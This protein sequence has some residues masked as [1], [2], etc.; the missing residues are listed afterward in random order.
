MDLSHTKGSSKN[1]GIEP[2]L[3]FLHYIPVIKEVRKGGQIEKFDIESITQ[4]A[5]IY[6]G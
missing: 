3:N 6:R 2:E 4:M 5:I 1:D